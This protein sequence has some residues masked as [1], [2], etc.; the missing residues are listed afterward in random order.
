MEVPPLGW[1]FQLNNNSF[2][3]SV[4]LKIFNSDAVVADRISLQI[5]EGRDAKASES[6]P[7]D[8][9]Q[10]FT[11]NSVIRGAWRRTTTA[12]ITALGGWFPHVWLKRLIQSVLFERL[13]IAI[14]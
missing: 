2:P 9:T 7:L 8:V 12:I 14:K 5:K 11:A 3:F 6:L 13:V 1:N 10:F 4:E